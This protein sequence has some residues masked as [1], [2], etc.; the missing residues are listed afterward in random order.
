[1]KGYI[2]FILI[3]LASCLFE[4]QERLILTK[5]SPNGIIVKIYYVELGATTNDVIQVKKLADNKEILL[6]AYEHN[7][8]KSA[9]FIEGNR[10]EMILTDTSSFG[11]SKKS[12][13]VMIKLK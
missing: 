7:F 4:K 5:K 12:D 2:F 13:T 9:K 1:M 8:I 6:K 10:L 11:M 3:L